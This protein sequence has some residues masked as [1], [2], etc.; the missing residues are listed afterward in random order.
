M[1]VVV[2]PSIP[3]RKCINLKCGNWTNMSKFYALEKM[4][5]INPLVTLLY[6][7]TKSYK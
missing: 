3:A 5:T 2:L 6:R 7:K 1:Y 4:L